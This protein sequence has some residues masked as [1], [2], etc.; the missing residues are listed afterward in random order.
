MTDI[1]LTSEARALLEYLLHNDADEYIRSALIG[2]QLL[3]HEFG[4]NI[5]VKFAL[6][7]DASL[8]MLV[9]CIPDLLDGDHKMYDISE[10][11]ERIHTTMELLMPGT[12][13]R[14]VTI[15]W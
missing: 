4:P 1:E 2:Y 11:I 8:P 7:C 6:G 15:L 12:Y 13:T 5:T 9:L 14:R 3:V 10:R